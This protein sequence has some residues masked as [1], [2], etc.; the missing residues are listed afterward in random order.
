VEKV[1]EC[2]LC[3]DTNLNDVC[4]VKEFIEG[5]ETFIIRKCLACGFHMTTPR[6]S[7][8]ELKK[9]YPEEYSAYH[10]DENRDEAAPTGI[11]AAIYREV[12]RYPFKTTR[13]SFPSPSWS[14]E[15]E[16]GGEESHTGS[17]NAAKPRCAAPT[18]E[19][20]GKDV[21]IFY[22]TVLSPLKP[23]LGWVPPEF[24]EDG[25]V[26][27]VG[28]STGDYLEFLKKLGWKETWGIENNPRPAE[29]A[30]ERKGLTIYAGSL[31]E[32][33]QPPHSFDAVTAWHVLEHV[34]DP[35]DFLR[36]A[37]RV[38]KNGGQFLLGLPNVEAADR[39]VFGPYWWPWEVPRHLWHFDAGSL[40]RLLAEAGFKVER[41][42]YSAHPN[43]LILSVR[44]WATRR[45]GI[46]S[47]RLA[48]MLDPDHPSSRMAKLFFLPW[49]TIMSLFRGA[50]TMIVSART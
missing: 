7:D 48:R 38:L 50:P 35:R 17:L 2:Y 25:R 3:G 22:R 6:P 8:E 45:L 28:C 24:V 18:T 40:S 41:V 13:S 33:F 42:T 49:S 43:P 19:G 9:Y 36:S 16:P 14:P 37:H 4:R 26:L 15:T 27:D 29:F 12:F 23:F 5:K 30:R 21:N 31:D 46:K 20:E 39:Q 10:F 32:N 1:T 11:R 34:R 44:T 47:L